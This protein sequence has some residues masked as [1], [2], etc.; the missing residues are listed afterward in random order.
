LEWFTREKDPQPV[1]EEKSIS[2]HQENSELDEM[3]G[4]E[5]TQV[6][7]LKDTGTS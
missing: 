4:R 6:V 2:E 1:Q 7:N 3:L 5:H